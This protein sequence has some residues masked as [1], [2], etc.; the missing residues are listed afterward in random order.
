MSKPSRPPGADEDPLGA[1]PLFADLSPR[2]RDRLRSF[3]TQA[4]VAA[5]KVLTAQGSLG[6]EFFIIVDGTASVSRD[7]EAVGSLGP[8]D[9]FGEVALLG[10]DVVRTATVTASTDMTLEVMTP[11]EM[12]EMLDRAPQIADLLQQ[13]MAGYQGTDPSAGD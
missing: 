9:T 5:G 1:V 13:K 10:D 6:R 2:E 4:H 7:G 11:P 12:R 3:M 8:G